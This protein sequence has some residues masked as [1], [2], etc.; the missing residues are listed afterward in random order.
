MSVSIIYIRLSSIIHRLVDV[1]S[2]P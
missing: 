2:V 1:G